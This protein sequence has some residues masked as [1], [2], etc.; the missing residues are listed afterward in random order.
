MASLLDRQH[1]KTLSVQLSY[2]EANSEERYAMSFLQP[3]S[4]T[5][6]V[7]RGA[8]FYDWAKWSNGMM[9][10]TPDYLKCGSGK[11]CQDNAQR[12]TC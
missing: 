3:K 7:Q 8:A 12:L 9:G 10:R 5:D 2:S 6:V 1:D 11:N 4:M